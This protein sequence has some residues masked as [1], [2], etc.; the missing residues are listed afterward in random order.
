LITASIV[1]H[2]QR[3]LVEHLLADL[4]LLAPPVLRRVVLTLNTAEEPP[5]S[6]ARLV[7]EVIV[8]RNQWPLGFG[9]NHNRAFVHCET[10]WF[11]VLNPDLRIP[12]EPFTLLLKAALPTDALLA[13]IIVEPDGSVADSARLVPTPMQLVRRHCGWQAAV[14]AADFDWVAGMFL[15]LRSDAFRA[16]R[17]FDERYFMYCEDADLCLRLQSAGWT[18]RLVADA[19]VVHEAQRA[20]RRSLRH[21]RWHAGS[22]LRLWRSSALKTYLPQRRE[23]I[24]RRRALNRRS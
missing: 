22:L 2:G 3:S 7:C 6:L 1:S 11:A 17:G 8:L 10:P 24:A 16:V 23:I 19:R 4:A 14:A 12:A 15:L 21:L 9:A 5:A 18:I 20:S 13:P